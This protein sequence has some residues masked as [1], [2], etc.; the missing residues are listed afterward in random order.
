MYYAEKVKRN[1]IKDNPLVGSKVMSMFKSSF[2]H[3]Q[4]KLGLKLFIAI[5]LQTSYATSKSF[6]VRLDLLLTQIHF[7]LFRIRHQS[8]PGELH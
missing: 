3:L 7:L 1:N 4:P 2:D 5:N 6:H 8:D